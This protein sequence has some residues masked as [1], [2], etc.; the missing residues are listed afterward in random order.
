MGREQVCTEG[1]RLQKYVK[2]PN[3]NTVDGN[4]GHIRNLRNIL[5][6]YHSDFIVSLLLL[7]LCPIFPDV[8]SN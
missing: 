1:V 5:S 6:I 3:D 7:F 4:G 8:L 2:Q